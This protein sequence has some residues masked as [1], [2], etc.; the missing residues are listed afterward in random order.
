VEVA[1]DYWLRVTTEAGTQA[2]R[3]PPRRYGWADPDY[4]VVHASIVPCNASFLRALRGEGEAETTGEDNYKTLELVFAAY[5]SARSGTA[6][7]LAGEP[8]NNRISASPGEWACA[9]G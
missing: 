6:V 9:T 1:R 2:K 3:H 8:R 4:A 5:E 7:R